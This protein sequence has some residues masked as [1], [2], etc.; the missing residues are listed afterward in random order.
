MITGI[1][2]FT[3]AHNFRVGVKK[4]YT[5][6]DHFPVQK[7]LSWEPC[8]LLTL[9]RISE[10]SLKRTETIRWDGTWKPS[11]PMKIIHEEI[12]QCISIYHI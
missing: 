7:K 10:A 12:N 4:Q 2:S 5:Q 6:W 1:P 11:L 3:T 9:R 8:Q